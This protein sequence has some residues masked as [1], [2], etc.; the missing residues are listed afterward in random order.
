LIIRNFEYLLALNK[1]RHF[2]RA[3]AACSVSQPTLSA[4]IK[5]LEEDMDVLIVKRGQRFEGLTREGDRVLA[6]AQQMLEDCMRLKHELHELRDSG[7]QGPFRLGMV[8][9]TS[10]LASV[11]SVAFAEKFPE[12]QIS[13]E[14]GD[15]ERLL[16]M[17]RQGEMDVALMYL[18]E[19]VSEGLDAYALYRERLFLLTTG[20]AGKG[21]RVSWEKVA[22]LPLCLLRSAV[23]R[24]AEIQLE[25][26]TRVIHTDSA[27]VMA[28][29]VGTGRWSTVLPQSLVT[30]LSKTPALQA[31]AIAKP[32]EQVNVG[33]VTVK[34]DPLPA[35]VH[36]LMEMAHTPELVDAIRGMLATYEDYVPQRSRSSK[37]VL[38]Q[39]S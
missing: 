28:A 15:P 1:E 30:M 27:A 29:H 18:D 13:M 37:P 6:W 24:T 11:L 26:A 9:A 22:T 25:K 8:P 4:G 33:F 7:M 39:Q 10:A 17:V 2:A 23:P 12:L 20:D 38:Q 21:R 34:S 16:Y 14:T 3:A 32:S 36:A 31:I 19:A 5:Q 35:A